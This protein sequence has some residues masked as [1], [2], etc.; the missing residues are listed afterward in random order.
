MMRW[1]RVSGQESVFRKA[2]AIKSGPGESHVRRD[3]QACL[4]GRD[5]PCVSLL[6]WRTPSPELPVSYSGRLRAR[7][8]IVHRSLGGDRYWRRQPGKEKHEVKVQK[9]EKE[10]GAS[11][12][13]PAAGIKIHQN[14][15]MRK[16]RDRPITTQNILALI[17]EILR[18][19]GG[20]DKVIAI[21]T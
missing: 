2:H 12:S 13:P 17:T 14:D 7:D 19:T 1:D 8:N 6:I 3:L 15:W 18:W 11:L 21:E 4:A 10:S 16:S 9:F 5:N 20:N